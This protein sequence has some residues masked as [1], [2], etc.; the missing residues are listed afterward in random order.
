M[1]EINKRN[2]ETV[3]L[4]LEDMNKKIREQQI[5]IDGLQAT[6]STLNNQLSEVLQTLNTMRARQSGR[7]PTVRE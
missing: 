2:A 6:I 4:S 5:Q 3:R 1:S 7:G